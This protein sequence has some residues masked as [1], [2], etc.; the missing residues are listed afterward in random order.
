MRIKKKKQSENKCDLWVPLKTICVCVCILVFFF[1][2]YSIAVFEHI[3]QRVHLSVSACVLYTGPPMAGA[4]RPSLLTVMTRW[5]V[6]AEFIFPLFYRKY[7]SGLQRTCSARTQKVKTQAGTWK[8]KREGRRGGWSVK[9]FRP[10]KQPRCN[11]SVNWEFSVFW[12]QHRWLGFSLL[13]ILS[14]SARW[15]KISTIYTHII[16]SFP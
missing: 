7:S 8:K 15:I 16:K 6:K 11:S 13:G 14:N 4:E 10:I 2:V 1:S 12:L 5:Q 9:M 3:L